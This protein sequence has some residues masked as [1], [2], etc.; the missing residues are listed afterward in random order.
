MD[1][2]IGLVNEVE[3]EVVQLQL[4]QRSLERLFCPI[5]PGIRDLQLSGDE[6]LFASDAAASDRFADGLLIAVGGRR[7]DEAV[8]HA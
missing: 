1:V 6:E 4:L 8:A 5:I 7:V 2:T 3:I